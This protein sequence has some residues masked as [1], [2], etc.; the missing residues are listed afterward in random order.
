MGNAITKEELTWQ[1]AQMHEQGIGGVEQITMQE[2]YEKGNVPYL[3]AEYFD[4]VRHAIQEAKARG[5]E[6][7]LNFGGPGWVIGGAWVPPE[8]RSQ[9]LIPTALQLAGGQRFSGSLPTKV[10]TVPS[11]GQMPARD[12]ADNDRLVAVVAG[13]VTGQ[14]LEETSLVDLTDQVEG[15]QLNWDVPDGTWQLMAFWL[16]YTGQQYAVDHV[17]KAAMQRYCSY[18]GNRFR[19]ALGADFGTTVESLFCDSFEVALIDNGIYWSD[20]L[21]AE[22]QTRQGYDLRRFLPAVWWDVGA[23]TP[24][25]RY[26][27]NEFLSAVG[28]EAFFKTFLDWCDSNGVRGRIQ[29]Y[30]FPT[31]IIQGAGLTH[32]PEMEI[33]PGEKDAV[34]WFDTRIGPKQ[35]VASGAHLYGRNVVTV[36]AYTYLHWEPCRATLEELK[37]ASDGF[38]RAGANKF[39]NHGFTCSPERDFAL[40]RRFGAEMVISPPNVWWHYYRLLSD[41]VARCCYLLQQGDFVAD[42]A[43]YSPLANQ[44]TRDVRNARKWTRSFDWGALGELLLANGYDFD[45]LNDDVLQNHAKI[46]GGVIRVRSLEYRVLLLPNIESLPLETLL[47]I[48]QYARDGGVV[49]A[50]ERVP[51]YAVGRADYQRKDAA[52]RAIAAKMFDTPV[53]RRNPT[54]PR[55]YGQGKT[56]HIQYVIDRSDVLERHSSALDPFLN[57]LRRHVRPDFGIDFVRAELRANGGL[58]FTH[59]RLPDRDIYFVTNIQ[60]RAVDMP[61]AFRVSGRPPSRWD[62]YC[63]RVTP[64]AEYQQETDVTWL[65]VRLA[66]YESTFVVFGDGP[67]RP[68]VT[69]STWAEIRRVEQGTVEAI[70]R[71]NGTHWVTLDHGAETQV[72]VTGIPAVY[73]IAGQWQLTLVGR[74]FPPLVTS[75]ARL[76]SWTDNARTKHFSG[77]G[78]YTIDFDLPDSYFADQLQLY[79]SLGVVGNVAE[80]EL[81]GQSIG[82]CWMRGQQLAITAAA[83]TGSNTLTVR[84]TNTLINRVAGF[85]ELPP[86][87]DHLV[88]RYGRGLPR[89][90]SEARGVI[91]FEPLP[92]SGLLGPVVIRPT[93]RVLVPIER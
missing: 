77:T 1:L 45:L 30:G 13:R 84:V 57:T 75:L 53:W 42:I 44:W 55:D 72:A 20:G 50:L 37:I 24:K 46:D 41:Y 68:H 70:A 6:F 28:L 87:P 86:V 92:N 93:K 49:V 29:P 43:V 63:G 36:E 10:G 78:V 81:N 31:D 47:R 35:Y 27:V 56:Y 51:E 26:D 60:D 33:T 39:Y 52:V 62:P 88:P 9:N 21:L 3:S 2:V 71:D 48:E 67:A 91:C 64:L 80:V 8:D 40:S 11:T 25:I 59:R 38:L 4:L 16:Q 15:R 32:L 74:D 85:K 23:I 65:P 90:R 7:S 19:D 54:A 22:F 69:S 17:N 82:T 89:N 83:R 76:V 5:M 18:L 12:V 61:V 79:L 14:R 34:P 58:S 73:E 66:P